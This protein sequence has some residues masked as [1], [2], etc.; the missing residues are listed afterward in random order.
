MISTRLRKEE[1]CCFH[2]IM[3][4]TQW[5]KSIFKNDSSIPRVL[6]IFINS[7]I[8]L[9]ILE[10]LAQ[11]S[12]YSCRIIYFLSKVTHLKTQL[13]FGTFALHK[14][15]QR[16]A[17]SVTETF[18]FLTSFI[19]HGIYFTNIFWANFL[20]KNYTTSFWCLNYKS[21]LFWRQ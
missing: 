5:V 14:H 20:H 8:I 2:D 10:I 15:W 17:F 16:V 12:I 6:Q 11:S 21:I 7:E 13:S 19:K 1:Y 9:I 18:E 3:H 4:V